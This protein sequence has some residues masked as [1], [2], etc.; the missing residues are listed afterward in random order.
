MSRF[1][2]GIADFVKEE[3]RMSITHNDMNLSTLIV[4]A[5]SIEESNFS[6][7]IS[8]LKRDRFYEKN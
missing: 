5:Q 3:C 2:S 1:V 4:D 6:R 8:N 7:I